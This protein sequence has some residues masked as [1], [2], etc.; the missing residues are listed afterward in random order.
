M[1]VCVL[2]EAG[3]ILVHENI[4]TDS[5]QFLKLIAPYR[6]DLV[7]TAECVFTWYWL[8]DLCHREQIPFVLGHALYMS[9]LG[10]S[11]PPAR[12]RWP[13]SSTAVPPE[14]SVLPIVLKFALDG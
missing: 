12:I 1:H 7:V 6:T 10:V 13:A 14:N 4:R 5:G 9:Q 3:K 8:A 2:D 11:R